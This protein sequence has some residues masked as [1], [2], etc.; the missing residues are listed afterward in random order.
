MNLILTCLINILDNCLYFLNINGLA[1]FTIYGLQCGYYLYFW[2]CLCVRF[3]LMRD[4]LN[5]HVMFSPRSLGCY[6]NWPPCFGM[7]F[8]KVFSSISTLNLLFWQHIYEITSLHMD[9]FLLE[10][11]GVNNC[12][13][14]MYQLQVGEISFRWICCKLS[15]CDYHTQVLITAT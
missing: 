9:R 11:P 1:V 4:G 15:R 12:Q 10:E 2:I 14:T 3:T 5:G 8:G 6:L 13:I 7:G